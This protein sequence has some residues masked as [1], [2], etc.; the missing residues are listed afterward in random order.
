MKSW[1]RHLRSETWSV[2]T[3]SRRCIWSFKRRGT[4]YADHGAKWSKLMAQ[5]LVD[6]EEVEKR[7]SSSLNVFNQG[8]QN[9]IESN[10][11]GDVS[12]KGFGS[13]YHCRCSN[14]VSCGWWITTKAIS[15]MRLRLL[16]LLDAMMDQDRRW[17]SANTRGKLCHCAWV[18]PLSC[19]CIFQ[20]RFTWSG[21]SVGIELA[22]PTFEQLKLPDVL[23]DLSIAKRGLVLVVGATLC[24][25]T[26]MAAMTGYRKYQPSSGISWVLED[27][28]EFV[29]R[30]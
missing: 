5:G 14:P 24:K 25:S 6:S 29:S 13:L 7:S 18:W 23:Q 12:P 10:P 22:I 27:P 4:W 28:I 3:R 26:S 21:H 2:K 9:G 19:Q 16:Q 30:T 11:W 8:E 1:W 15:W 20:R 17:I